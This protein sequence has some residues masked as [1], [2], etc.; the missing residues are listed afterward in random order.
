MTPNGSAD[1]L[2]VGGGI[3]GA[4]LALVLARGGVSVTVLERQT[5]YHDRVRG[6]LLQPWG[7]AEAQ[8]LGIMD[9]LLGAGGVFATRLV[10][11][12]ELLPPQV[13]EQAARDLSNILPDVPGPLC[14][15]HPAAC[16]ALSE[17]PKRQ[18][19]GWYAAS[20]RSR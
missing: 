15:G 5:A 2:V 7:V 10:V 14:A 3:A 4:A 8:R 19:R 1:V 13:T 16:R 17:P 20:A 11:Y 6:E 12:D 9:A 18:G